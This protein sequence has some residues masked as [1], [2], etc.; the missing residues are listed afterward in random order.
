[1]ALTHAD[2][3]ALSKRF[4][5]CPFRWKTSSDKAVSPFGLRY[6]LAF[7]LRLEA[8]R[9]TGR[10]EA[11]QTELAKAIG[12]SRRIVGKYIEELERKQVC[13]VRP[14][15]NQYARTRFEIRD[16]FWPYR[17]MHE[18]EVSKG[19][20]PHA[21][22]DAVKSRFLALGCTVGKFSA[23][24][25]QF[26]QELYRRGVPL[27]TVQDALLMGGVRKYVSWLNGGSPQPIGSLAYFSA[28]VSEIEERPLPEGYRDYLQGKVAQLARA[29]AKSS[30]KDPQNGGCHDR[31]LSW[32]VQ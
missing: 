4:I 17:R 29:W 12:K 30:L 31:P 16:G 26:A 27:E 32:I 23:R 20:L 9:R 21:Y 13:T 8:D 28:L 10:M 5:G 11:V 18:I 25:G 6:A 15:R 3:H 1:L 7:H 22:V 14:G 2:F 24:D 19:Q